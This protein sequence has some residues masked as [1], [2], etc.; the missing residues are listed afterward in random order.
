M[1]IPLIYVFGFTTAPNGILFC[2]K[3][4][5]Y[6]I[7]LFLVSYLLDAKFQVWLKGKLWG[8][9]ARLPQANA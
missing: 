9:H 5:T 6:F 4:L 8:R 7:V 2:V 3:V 1:H